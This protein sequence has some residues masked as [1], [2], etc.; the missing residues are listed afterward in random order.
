MPCQQ[1]EKEAVSRLLEEVQKG[2]DCPEED[3][4]SAEEVYRQLELDST[5]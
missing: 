5:E 2:L 3:W 4:L 1:N